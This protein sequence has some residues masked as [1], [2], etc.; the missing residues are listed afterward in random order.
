[1]TFGRIKEANYTSLVIEVC[2][3][4]VDYFL[5]RSVCHRES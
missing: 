2:S 4:A 5:L 1:M 3:V